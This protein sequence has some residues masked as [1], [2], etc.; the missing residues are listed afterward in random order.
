MPHK[1]PIKAAEYMANY[2]ARNSEREKARMAE[3]RKVN[4]AKVKACSKRL[5]KRRLERRRAEREAILHAIKPII[6]HLHQ[7]KHMEVV[8]QGAK[9]L[10]ESLREF[11]T[12]KAA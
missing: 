7:P 8:A 10:K 9:R 6:P 2:Y 3:W 5:T 4:P 1:D 11:L 12:R